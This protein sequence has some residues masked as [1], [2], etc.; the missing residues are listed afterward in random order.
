MMDATD[1]EKSYTTDHSKKVLPKYDFY[2]S[3]NFEM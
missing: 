3:A 1:T 2:A